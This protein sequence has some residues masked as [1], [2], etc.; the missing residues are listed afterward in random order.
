MIYVDA[1]DDYGFWIW[2]TGG[3]R[4]S[5]QTNPLMVWTHLRQQPLLRQ[6]P[7]SQNWQCPVKG[8][9]ATQFSCMKLT[10]PLP[11]LRQPSTQVSQ[12]LP[13]D[14]QVAHPYLHWTHQSTFWFGLK[15]PKYPSLHTR[16]VEFPSKHSRQLGTLHYWHCLLF[17]QQ[18]GQQNEQV[19]LGQVRQTFNNPLLF[20]EQEEH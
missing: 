16:H 5:L 2:T 18:P 14:W 1:A 15:F 19:L 7:Q 12:T 8:S 11:C 17:R 13:G 4:L 3:L 6:Q 10:Q 20:C 9:T